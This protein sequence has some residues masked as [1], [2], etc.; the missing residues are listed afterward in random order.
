MGGFQHN[1]RL[2]SHQTLADQ[3]W[4]KESYSTVTEFISRYPSDLESN[5]SGD[6]QGLTHNETH[7]FVST[8]R[9]ARRLAADKPA[10]I[11]KVNLGRDL[12]KDFETR[13]STEVPEPFKSLKYDHFGDIDYFEG[14]IFAPLERSGGSPIDTFLLIFDATDLHF[15]GSAPFSQQ[16]AHNSMCQ[17]PWCAVNP[18]DKLLYSSLFESNELIVYRVEIKINAV[19]LTFLRSQPLLDHNGMPL[20]IKKIQG[21]AF[22]TTSGLFYISNNSEENPGISV[23]DTL[24]WKHAG[25]VNVDFDQGGVAQEEIEGLTLWDLSHGQDLT[26][27]GQIHL[28]ILNNNLIADDQVSIVHFSESAERRD[29]VVSPRSPSCAALSNTRKSL[30]RARDRAEDA[31][32]RKMLNIRLG[33]NSAQMRLL[34]C[35]MTEDEG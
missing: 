2:K 30:I 19:K 26:L 14:K 17:A 29:P 13:T 7:W 33:K 6:C 24:T 27:S 18:K 3:I 16:A 12:N 9:E 15:I 34:G 4:K 35:L 25:H 5:W 20:H 28:V 22:S 11:W 1:S 10:R 8:A 23:F 21:G 31:N 32:E